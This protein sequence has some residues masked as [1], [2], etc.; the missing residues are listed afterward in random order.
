V[1]KDY[2]HASIVRAFERAGATVVE[3]HTIGRGVPDL[4]VGYAGRDLLVEVKL[5]RRTLWDGRESPRS[6]L[7][8]RQ[9][10]WHRSWR[11]ATPVVVRDEAEAEAL[12]DALA[13][14]P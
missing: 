4:L 10:S 13:L 5:P 9:S 7:S 8:R 12:L 1:G 3:L 14:G 11:G 6:S 2:N